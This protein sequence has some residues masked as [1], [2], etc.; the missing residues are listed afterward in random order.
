MFVVF[1]GI[2]G[3]G[4][5]TVSNRVAKR[6][7]EQGLSVKHLRAEGKF[8]SSVTQAIRELGRDARNLE[9]RPRAE[10]LLYVA[11]DVQLIEEALRPALATHDV[12]LADRFLYSAEVLAREGRHLPESELAPTLRM[13]AGGLVPDLVVLIDAE[14]GLARARRKAAKRASDDRRPPS[15][16]GL[17]GVGLQTRLRDGYRAL[18]AAAPE[19]WVVIDND[20][21]AL[22]DTVS[23]VADLIA[24]ARQTTPGAAIARFSAAGPPTPLPASAVVHTPADALA[25]FLT[26]V[27]QRMIAEPS[28]AAYLLAGLYGPEVDQRRWSLFEREPGAV[29]AAAT[30][31]PDEASWRMRELAADQ[32]PGVVARSLIALA[33]QPR[34][35][36][37]R[38]RLLDPA[39]VEVLISLTGL[40]D[41]AAWSMRDA[42]FGRAP[43]ACVQSLARISGDRAR[44]MR[45]AWWASSGGQVA[46][47]YDTAR[48]A[49]RSVTGLADTTAWDWRRQ[50]LA[51]APVAALASLAGVLDEPSWGWREKYL[52]LATKVVMASLNGVDG[53]RAFALR[54]AVADDC[55][56]ALD[57][58]IGL[59]SEPAWTL[60]TRY[61]DKWPSTV[62]KSL[63]VLADTPR[64]REVVSRQLAH[65]GNHLSLL[66]HATA[67]ALGLHRAAEPDGLPAD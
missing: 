62:V 57:S 42:L 18:A 64:G 44:T 47:H 7:G 29:L 20:D 36:S 9:L 1:E 49:A 12:V 21:R 16:K 54:A 23:R 6:L 28:V 19:R 67:I 34:A 11:R 32:H 27:D 65:H 60:R 10:F 35:R 46:D 2:D 25:A 66:K 63:G 52:T 53:E 59:G 55:K 30:G 5:T 26:A 38:E 13:A 58:V 39:G 56:E 22:D 37:L 61:L 14:P 40:S 41:E 33:N 31:L 15:R 50:S 17:A 43:A 4:K 8:A 51:A 45:E 3:S 48:V 24:D